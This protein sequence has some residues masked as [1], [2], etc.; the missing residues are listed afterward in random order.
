MSEPGGEWEQCLRTLHD[1]YIQWELIV[2]GGARLHDYYIQW[3]LICIRASTEFICDQHD[4][5]EKEN[6]VPQ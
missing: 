1:Y 2:P 4:T 3:E 6:F 5:R